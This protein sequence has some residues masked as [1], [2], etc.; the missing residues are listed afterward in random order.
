MRTIC[1]ILLA[2]VGLLAGGAARAAE[3]AGDVPTVSRDIV[4]KRMCDGLVLSQPTKDQLTV[5][6]RE[7]MLRALRE[8]VAKIAP[9]ILP[10]KLVGAVDPGP[11]P[12]ELQGKQVGQ[13]RDQVIPRSPLVMTG[14]LPLAKVQLKMQLMNIVLILKYQRIYRDTVS[15]E[16][17]E[18]LRATVGRF[19]DELE[20]RMKA[21]LLGNGLPF[22]EDEIEAQGKSARQQLLGRIGEASSHTMTQPV[23]NKAF[24]EMMV[25]LDRSLLGKRKEMSSALKAIKG[26]HAV[27][28]EHLREQLGTARGRARLLRD[29]AGQT[30]R[31]FLLSSSRPDL[32]AVDREQLVPGYSAVTKELS[33][34][35][36]EEARGRVRRWQEKRQAPREPEQHRPTGVPAPER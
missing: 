10:E 2:V 7:E 11:L 30:R 24:D 31:T 26:E 29:I 35:R 18:S 28:A 32:L 15:Q 23:S 19:S 36:R 12:K 22:T 33:R 17:L 8:H 5:K 25:E 34:L 4:V 13:R 16:T 1:I 6:E 3:E 21:Q 27:G 9:D 20:K 14:G